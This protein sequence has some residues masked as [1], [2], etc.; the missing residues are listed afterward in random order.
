MASSTCEL[1]GMPMGIGIL[2]EHEDLRPGYES[3]T[4]IRNVTRDM[5]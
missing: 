4:S 1:G 2:F 3:M 5:S